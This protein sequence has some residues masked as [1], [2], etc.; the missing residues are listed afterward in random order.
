MVYYDGKK[1]MPSATAIVLSS[2]LTIIIFVSFATVVFHHKVDCQVCN[3]LNWLYLL[4][5]VKVLITILKFY[6]QVLSN[7]NRKSTQGWNI[8]GTW[9]DLLGSVLS[10][11]QL[12]L[13]CNDQNDWNGIKGNFVKIALGVISGSYDV[14]FCVQHY[15][16]YPGTGDDAVLR[17]KQRGGGEDGL[18]LSYSQLDATEHGMDQSV[19]GHVFNDGEEDDIEEIIL[20]DDFLEEERVTI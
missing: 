9:L 5:T 15:L 16:I 19:R 1:Q 17:K 2:A 8:Y 3:F 13:D 11:L 4:S 12:V 10:I 14:I 6:P 7:Y 20:R 18:E